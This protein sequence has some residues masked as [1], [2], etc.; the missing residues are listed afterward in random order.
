MVGEKEEEVKMELPPLA[1]FKEERV[2]VRMAPPQTA[3]VAWLWTSDP[4][5]QGEEVLLELRRVLASWY[6]AQPDELWVGVRSYGRRGFIIQ[7][8]VG[9]E[10]MVNPRFIPKPPW[11]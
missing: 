6:D 9:G 4:T 3:L 8:Q 1:L 2:V 5:I 10:M 7:A 11:S